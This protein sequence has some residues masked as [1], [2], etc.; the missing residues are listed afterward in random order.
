MPLVSIEATL[1]PVAAPFSAKPGDSLLIVAGV[2]LGLAPPP[3]VAASRPEPETI[4]ALIRDHGPISAIRIGDALALERGAT[5]HRAALST[6]LQGLKA[7]GLITPTGTGRRSMLWVATER[8][9]L[10]KPTTTESTA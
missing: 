9:T 1:I 2:C 8:G 3:P 6:A 7:A 10:A 4:L 5:P